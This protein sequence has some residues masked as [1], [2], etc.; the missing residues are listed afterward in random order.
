MRDRSV[1]LDPPAPNPAADIPWPGVAA[2]HRQAWRLPDDLRDALLPV[3]WLL[4]GLLASFVY[5]YTASFPPPFSTISLPHPLFPQQAVILTILLL[6]PLRRWWLYLLVYYVLQVVLGARGNLPLWYLLLSN[7][8]NVVEPLVGAL[9]CRRFLS[10][11]PRFAR[12]REV[13][14]YIACVM[15]ASVAGATW[16]ATSRVIAGFP[17]WMS[18]PGWF[19]ADSLAS[20]VLAPALILWVGAGLAGF[21]VSSRQRTIEVALLGV[22]LVLVSVFVFGARIETPDRAQGLLY[23]PVPVL[24]WAAVRFGPRGLMTALSVVLVFAIAGVANGFGPFVGH[25]TPANVY[26]LQLFLYGIGV[27]LFCLAALVQERQEAEAELAQSEARYRVVASNFPHGA[28]LLF[29]PDL[30]HLLADGQGLSEAGLSKEAVEGRTL[31]EAFPG[32]M[33]DALALPYRAALAGDPTALE[34]THEGR[35]YQVQVLPV[36]QAAA[37]AAAHAVTA[38]HDGT[39]THDGTT[40][41]DGTATGMV[42]MQDV[43]EQRRAE[44]LAELDQAKTAFFSNVSHEFRTPLTLLLG[45]LQELVASPPQRLDHVAQEQLVVA[46]RNGLRLLKLV[47]Q[48]LDFSRLEAGHMQPVYVPTDLA[49]YTAELA[50]VFRSAIERAGLRFVVHCPRLEEPVYVDRDQWEK[51]VL[52]LL[53]NALKFTFTG[54]IRLSLLARGARVVLTVRDTGTGIPAEELPH[55]FERFHRVQGA[56]GRTHEGTGIGLALV[57]ELVRLHT[58]TVEV[59]SAVGGG[60][61]VTVTVPCGTA[62]LPAGHIGAAEV[63]G[64]SYG[65]G[66]AAY[67]EEAWRWLPDAPRAISDDAAGGDVAAVSAPAMPW[68]AHDLDRPAR[69]LVAD[70]NADMRAYLRR[71]LRG[72]GTVQLVGDGT[73]AL[74]V[75]RAWEPDL[76]LADVMMP[77]LDGFALLQAVRAD[78]QLRPISVILLSARA[79]EAARIEALRA[80]ADDYLVKPFAA[81]TLLA[82]VDAQLG[83]VRLRGEAWAAAE[84]RR[85]ARE[86]HDSVSQALFAVAATASSL[87]RL[88]EQDADEGRQA[89]ADL[90]RL[91][92]GAQAEMRALLVELRPESLTRAPLHDL[93]Q[94]LVT[95]AAAKTGAAVDSQLEPVPVL[96]A[97]VQVAL[98]RIA[99]EALHNV[100]KHAAATHIS[101]RL[102]AMSRRTAGERRTPDARGARSVLDT[103]ETLL[104]EVADDGRGF[105]PD[106]VHSGGLGL[107]SLCE[108]AASIGASLRLA[109][110]PGEGTI[111]AAAWPGAA[112]ATAGSPTAGSAAPTVAAA[113]VEGSLAARIVSRT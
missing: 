68:S 3:F 53:S 19:L 56:Q 32:D 42:V 13:G 60:T 67:V 91:T 69:L 77:G 104:L 14:T 16:G 73:A 75:A 93:L 38:T 74:E 55:L 88:W 97:D 58:G 11:P 28:V 112:T 21:R 8:A 89:L 71:L 2:T 108:R 61:T 18:W 103:P 17:F 22:A 63:A 92:S 62:H 51:I 109:S 23:L 6:T 85:L 83:L 26:T 96:P 25:P 76:I 95:T 1:H 29:G 57:Q 15:V 100:V 20:L 43:T 33:A 65:S 37:D 27:P 44:V 34:L 86:L 54:E 35:T 110:H 64:T 24:M 45:S 41:H 111:I 102:N 4:V 10:L 84:R 82:R 47:N 80:G 49:A 101:V 79:D 48:L 90:R 7:V 78:A 12:L 36:T 40:T 87:P 113:T 99:Q 94:T 98:Y 52:N 50:G 5:T 106:Q 59:A 46:H 39:V 31:W 81:A 72:R 30:R 105:D 66:A 107:A 70:D 9:L